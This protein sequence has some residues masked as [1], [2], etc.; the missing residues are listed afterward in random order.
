MNET[1]GTSENEP[2]LDLPVVDRQKRKLQVSIW[3]LLLLIAACGIWIAYRKS[4]TDI[5]KFEKRLTGLRWIA[6]ELIVEDPQQLAAVKRLPKLLGE[7]I[8]DVH[9]PEIQGKHFDMRLIMD[10]VPTNSQSESV[11]LE[12]LK[13]AVLMPGKHAIELRYKAKESQGN[14]ILTVLV[15]GETVIEEIRLED[16]VD[17]SGSSSSSSVGSNSLSFDNEQILHLLKLRFTIKQKNGGRTATQK[18]GPGIFL[19]IEMV[20]DDKSD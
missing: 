15:D 19:W 4:V 13:H 7:N 17:S 11:Q 9:I 8:W 14:A 3:S 10:D 6:R 12:P 2:D 16:W 20:S 5:A 18:P 1:L